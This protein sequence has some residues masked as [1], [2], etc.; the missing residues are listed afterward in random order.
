MV[1]FTPKNRYDMQDLLQVVRILRSPGGCPWDREQTHESIRMSFVEETYEVL[2]A[3]DQ[4]DAELLCEELGDVLLHVVMHSQMECEKGN[5]TF[6]D[7]C[8]GV[9]EK[10][11]ARHPHVFGN[12]GTQSTDEV[13]NA[14][15]LLKNKEK[16]RDTAQAD[17]ES[18]PVSLPALMRAAKTQK[19]AA[20][21]GVACPNLD[22]A[23][24]L[25]E[26]QIGALRKAVQAGENPQEQVGALLSGTVNAARLAQVDPEDALDKSTDRFMARVISCEQL[27]K[28]QGMELKD[29]TSAQLNALWQQA[30]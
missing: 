10:M 15:D 27:A 5:F 30:K 11:I 24:E 28:Q 4:K 17:L 23:L 21:Y 12:A 7:V 13:I 3:I 19:R 2:D 6:E 18:V 22:T 8:N 1:E 26:Q 16:N 25:L 9:C 14:W 29:L 20:R